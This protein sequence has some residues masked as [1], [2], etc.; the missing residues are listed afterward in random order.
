MANE[1]LLILDD[2][3]DICSLLCRIAK[4]FGYL[5]KATTNP[6]TFLAD[7][8]V[9]APEIVVIDMVMPE[10]DGMEVVD[11]LA[12]TGYSGKIILMT[13]H[14]PSYTEHAKNLG[15]LGGIYKIRRIQKPFSRDAFIE[16]LSN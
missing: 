2:E 10:M 13:G 11:I 9:L 8:A 4:A 6:R 16:A 1:R 15:E 5:T 12:K 3:Q 7:L 14:N